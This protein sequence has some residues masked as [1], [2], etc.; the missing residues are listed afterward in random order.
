MRFLSFIVAQGVSG[1]HCDAEAIHMSATQVPCVR[2]VCWCRGV[3]AIHTCPFLCRLLPPHRR[4]NCNLLSP[5]P[6]CHRLIFRC[7]VCPASYCEDCLPPARVVVG[8]SERL[9]AL[10]YRLPANACY[11]QCTEQCTAFMATPMYQNI[12]NGTESELGNKSA[13]DMGVGAIPPMG[14][15]NEVISS[16]LPGDTA[17]FIYD[18]FA[19]AGFDGAM[20]A[21]PASP[22]GSCRSGS[23]TSSD[24][25]ESYFFGKGL[26][27]IQQ[28]SYTF[29]QSQIQT[30]TS[31]SQYSHDAYAAIPSLDQIYYMS[32]YQE[33]PTTVG[34]YAPPMAVVGGVEAA[35]DGNKAST[36]PKR[37]RKSASF[38][39]STAVAPLSLAPTS[40]ASA[41]PRSFL[42]H[43]SNF[44]RFQSNMENTSL[45]DLIARITRDDRFGTEV[46]FTNLSEI[47]NFDYRFGTMHTSVRSLLKA[48]IQV[49]HTTVKLNASSSLSTEGTFFHDDGDG[50]LEGGRAKRMKT[51]DGAEGGDDCDDENDDEEDVG[52]FSG[53]PATASKEVLANVF[54]EVARALTKAYRDDLIHLAKLL[55]ICV[56]GNIKIDDKGNKPEGLRE[57]KFR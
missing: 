5:L 4:P 52:K 50:R 41:S 13:I 1:L 31:A 49:V 26:K 51:E 42:V 44:G 38:Y 30:L 27:A 6:L 33:Y 19:G 29:T 20:A 2:E 23:S 56:L 53:V 22:T 8:S 7:E 47:T 55:G 39:A 24:E 34:G 10:G 25:D 36:A 57:P 18:G 35:D 46:R 21:V 43:S 32:N 14:P 12:V 3:R 15:A 45:P 54:L 17:A 16:T 9:E 11:V 48:L 37:G 28:P 40:G